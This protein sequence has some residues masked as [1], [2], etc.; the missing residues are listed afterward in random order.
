MK[1]DI[2]IAQAAQL[3]P[4]NKVA[5]SIGIGEKY[6]EYYGQYK[7]KISDDIWNE[8]GSKPDGKLVLVTAMTPTPAG[9][10][11]T[12][13]TVGLG[14]ALWGM[15]KKATI[16]LREPSLGPVFGIKGGAAG[17]GNSQVLPM[18]DINLHFTGDIHAITAANNLLSSVIDNHIHHGNELGINPK[19]IGWK[20]CLDMSDRNLREV[21]VGLGAGNGQ[22]REDG[23]IITVASE[24][25][26]ALCLSMGL[27]DLKRRLEKIVVAT[28]YSNQ[29]VYAKD[30]KVA[31]SMVVLLKDAIKPN[32][33]QTLEGSPAFIHGGPFAN[34]AHGCNSLAA[35]RL[36]LKLSDIV[37]TE[38]GFGS[39]LGAEKFIDIKC[40][41]GKLTPSAVV[42]V[43]TVRALKHHGHGDLADGLAN[44][45]KHINNLQGFNLPVVVA[46]NKFTG[47]TQAEYQMITD[48]CQERGVKMALSEVWEKGGKGGESLARIV[49]DL[50]KQPTAFKYLYNPNIGPEKVM[51]TIAT[52]IYGADGVEWSDKAKQDL[53]KF[54]SWGIKNLPVC[55]AKTQASISDNPKLLGAP[56][57]YKVVV[58][59][60][61]LSNGA[62]FIVMI[63]GNVMRM[64]GLPKKP[65]AEQIDINASGKTV[66][67]F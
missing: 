46:L 57:N 52:K 17:G 40:R 19:K 51:E 18:E 29:P 54:E 41:V 48:Y 7:A 15:G 1:S 30:L 45:G 58:R 5:K 62:G 44:L 39:D 37:V 23:F 3:L 22:V 64:P 27:K 14:Q 43:A 38:A 61:S 56:S 66:G 33:V 2:E 35:T 25:M 50:I 11:K 21:L 16:C 4:I 67:L 34:I 32:L 6:L 63:A 10:G 47:D 59:E 60:V 28:T 36:A 8:V 65:A 20:R 55:V 31:G 13:T 42:L 12:T 24:I 53:K 26:A 49:L 9:E